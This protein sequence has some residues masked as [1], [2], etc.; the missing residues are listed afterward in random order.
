MIV[1]SDIAGRLPNVVRPGASNAAAMSLRTLFFA[2][3]TGTSPASL[4]PPVTRSTCIQKGYRPG[5]AIHLTRIYTRTGDDGTTA[6]GDMSVSY[7]H[8]RAHETDS[9]IV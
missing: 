4:A 6:L 9:Y 7:T 2:P 1:T 8:L 5:M 3:T